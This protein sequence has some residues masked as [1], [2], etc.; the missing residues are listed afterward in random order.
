MLR[1]ELP[2]TK[3]K[4]LSGVPDEESDPLIR[5]VRHELRRDRAQMAADQ[6]GRRR[7]DGARDVVA[8][9][10]HSCDD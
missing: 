6:W 3:M 9:A 10:T 5:E 8:D 1:K 2:P 7:A 4:E